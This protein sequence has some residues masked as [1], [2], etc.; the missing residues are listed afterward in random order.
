MDFKT[1]DPKF[2]NQLE[3]EGPEFSEIQSKQE[4]CVD[5]YNGGWNPHPLIPLEIK[6]LT[7][8]TMG[9]VPAT[10]FWWRKTS[11]FERNGN[12]RAGK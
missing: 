1:F 6:G 9:P 7:Q 8:R 11:S 10:R 2:S 12:I 5:K 4:A 3:L